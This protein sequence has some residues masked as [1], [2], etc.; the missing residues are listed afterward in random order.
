MK[1]AKPLAIAISALLAAA[2]T[3]SDAVLVGNSMI[4]ASAAIDPPVMRAVDGIKGW[5]RTGPPE[6]YNR[7]GLYGYIDGGAEIVLSYGFRELSVFRFEP[8]GPEA[9]SKEAVLEIY[10]MKSGVA[11]L[12]LY[13]TKLEG[14]EENWPGIPADNWIGPGQGSLVKGDYL[15]NVLAPECAAPEIGA[16]LAAVGK[17]LP[18]RRTVRPEGLSRLPARDM[19]PNSRRYILGPVAARNESPFLEGDFWGFGGAD[20]GKNVSV[21]YSGKY[22]ASRAVSKLAVVELGRAVDTAAVDAGVLALFEEYLQDVARKGDV[23]EGRNQ[24]GRWFLFERAG[25]VAALVLGD[26]DRAAAAA[27]LAQSLAGTGK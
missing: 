23:L 4:A 27:R 7:E 13:S 14:G 25:A 5:K 8:A 3:G 9:S 17:K 22:G 1:P 6:R 18:A 20:T 10:R 2:C 21:A 24:A 11:A 16:F 26:P 19:V 15:V 12:G